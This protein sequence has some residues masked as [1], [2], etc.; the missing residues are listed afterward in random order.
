V[1][2]D[3]FQPWTTLAT[4]VVSALLAVASAALALA[5]THGKLALGEAPLIPV[6]YAGAVVGFGVHA[7]GK[8]QAIRR[9]TPDS[10]DAD[11]TVGI[12][13]S[14]FCFMGA[15]VLTTVP[16]VDPSWRPLFFVPAACMV[17]L[18]LG[19]LVAGNRRVRE[20]LGWEVLE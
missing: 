4:A 19:G 11:P 14:F 5:S 17:L 8:A 15:V 9:E 12:G 10:R 18:G 1:T 13:I 20:R 2:L 3:R 16:N 6:A 7:A